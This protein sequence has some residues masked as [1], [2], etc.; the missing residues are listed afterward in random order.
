MGNLLEG[1]IE[2]A[3]NRRRFLAKTALFSAATIAASGLRNA[4]GQTTSGPSDADILNFALNLEYLEA[5]FYTVATTGMTI[6]KTGID[7]TGSGKSVG[8]AD[9]SRPGPRLRQVSI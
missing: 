7:I 4:E 6:D 2:N 5:E 8:A 9:V 1:A 3:P